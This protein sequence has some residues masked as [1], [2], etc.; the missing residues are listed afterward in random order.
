[1]RRALVAPLAA[2]A[3]A[4]PAH[5]G[6]PTLVVGAADDSVRQPTLVTAKAK[7]DLMRLAG[8]RAVRMS[9]IWAPGLDEPTPA[10]QEQL[11]VAAAAAQLTGMRLYVSV[12]NAG[13]RTTPLTDADQADFA[14]YAAAVAERNPTIR[15]IVIGNEPNLNRFW[16]PQFGLDGSNAAAEAYLRLLGRAYDA[17]KAV[18]PTITVIGGAL[19][20]R[21]NDR[22]DGI[23]PTHSPTAFIR[24]LGTAYRASG[25]GRPVM[26][27]LAIHPYQ[28]NSS[29]PPETTHPNSTTI[30]IADY[31]KL[32]AL[33]GAA[34]D[35]TAQRGSTLPIFY[36]EFGVETTIPA[37]KASLYTGREP[38]TIK[39]VD[40]VLQGSYYRRALALAFCQPNVVGLLFFHAIDD[41]DLDRWQSGIYYV[42]ETAKESLP[43]VRR[44]ARDVRGGVVA[45][46]AGLSLTP[47]ATVTYP[48]GAAT[49][50]V[51]LKVRLLCDIDCLYRVR[52]ERLPRRSTTLSVTGSALAGV[53]KTVT[54]PAR[55]VAPG[56]YRF[57]VRLRALVN[58]GAPATRASAP[59]T[60]R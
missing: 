30:A 51:P 28:D 9:S 49:Q 32:V 47:K 60:I 52:L 10:E 14:S 29:V 46:C 11:A 40:P 26:D 50:A 59:F 3:L 7:L 37:N 21:G 31:D 38:A 34:F 54:L 8:I 15:H 43:A 1:V 41:R 6:G 53:R 16:L 55:R 18:S 27:Q 22:P 23:R 39:P 44:A 42:D 5:A 45:R 48:A 24:D 58:P 20:P 4:A 2:L 57:A 25:R 56:R 36:G 12:H 33:L 19:S 35:G 13:S 17:L